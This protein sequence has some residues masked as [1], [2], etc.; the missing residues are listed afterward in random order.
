[1]STPRGGFDESDGMLAMG[2]AQHQ[3]AVF[4][5]PDDDRYVV[6]RFGRDYVVHDNGTGRPWRNF[7]PDM[8]DAQAEAARLNDGARILGRSLPPE[9]EDTDGDELAIESSFL[10]DY[11]PLVPSCGPCGCKGCQGKPALPLRARMRDAATAMAEQAESG[12][13]PVLSAEAGRFLAALMHA[14]ADTLPADTEDYDVAFA[15]GWQ[16]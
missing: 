7:G 2:D 3:P 15:R 14:Y 5:P 6:L 11:D 4:E 8:G 16:P 1:M 10:G 13:P 9:E 12:Q